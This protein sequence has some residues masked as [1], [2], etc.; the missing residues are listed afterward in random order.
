MAWGFICWRYCRK[1]GS[2]KEISSCPKAKLS[3]WQVYPESI[4]WVSVWQST[5]LQDGGAA[6]AQET[7]VSNLASWGQIPGILKL[8]TIQES[9]GQLSWRIIFQFL[10]SLLS[11]YWPS[12]Q[13]QL[14]YK[15]QYVMLNLQKERNEHNQPPQN[16][17]FKL[18]VE[19]LSIYLRMYRNLIIV[20][21]IIAVISISIVSITIS[22]SWS[23]QRCGKVRKAIIKTLSS[24]QILSCVS[25]PIWINTFFSVINLCSP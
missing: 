7:R 12:F 22:A 9:S 21:F 14:N 3:L 16:P 10:R 23:C 25:W 20:V 8:F 15:V 11:Y 5:I 24:L 4:S 2:Q 6:Q 18:Q 17:K 13:F 1:R 19:S